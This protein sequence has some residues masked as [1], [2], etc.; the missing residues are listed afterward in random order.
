MKLWIAIVALGIAGPAFAEDRVGLGTGRLATND[1]FGDGKDRWRTASYA[2]SHLRGPEW[3]GRAP[4]RI[5]ALLE[6]RFGAE[7]IA[8]SSLTAVGDEDRPYAAALSLGLHSHSSL[9]AYDLRLG[10]DLVVVGPQSG[11]DELHSAFHEQI[12]AADPAVTATQLQDAILGQGSF[13]ISR[14]VQVND[15]VATRTFVEGYVGPEDLIRIGTDISFGTVGQNE[16]MV[17]DRVTGQLYRGIRQPGRG[18]A[19]TMGADAARVWDSAFLPADRGTTLSETRYRLRA[20]IH[21]QPLE[22]RYLFYGVTYLSPEFEEQD[23]GQITGSIT[24]NFSF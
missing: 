4:D 23:D 1:F 5:G 7:I 10:A 6:Y 16:L 21:G 2:F 11:L 9:G 24:V 3:Q 15:R 17:R 8:P 20:G 19:L 12:G 22:N 18:W 13:E 14:A